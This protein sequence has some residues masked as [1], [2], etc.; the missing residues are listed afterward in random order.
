MRK[1]GHQLEVL[2][3]GG[4]Q[5]DIQG[6]VGNVIKA[7]EVVRPQLHGLCLLV[8]TVTDGVHLSTNCPGE[9]LQCKVTK[10]TK[11]HNTNLQQCSMF[12]LN[13]IVCGS[14]WTTLSV[15]ATYT[16]GYRLPCLGTA[17]P[18]DQGRQHQ[19]TAMQHVVLRVILSG[20]LC[21]ALAVETLVYTSTPTALNR[22]L[23]SCTTN[24][25]QVGHQ[26]L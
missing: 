21:I 7:H 26:V 23:L 8:W 16:F 5:D 13:V 22:S 20:S 11:T 24:C 9:E 14:L 15:E 3:W 4:V 6:V 12:L 25:L 1:R 10:T 2:P 17:L 18:S 19:L